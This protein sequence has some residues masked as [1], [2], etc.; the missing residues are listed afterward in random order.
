LKSGFSV[1]YFTAYDVDG[2]GNANGLFFEDFGGEGEFRFV[3]PASDVLINLSI[4][5]N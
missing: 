5:K 2:N 3:M 1:D 4:I